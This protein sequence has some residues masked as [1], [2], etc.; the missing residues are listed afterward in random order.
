MFEST[1]SGPGRAL[2]VLSPLARAP[3][4]WEGA[5]PQQIE[6]LAAEL[7]FPSARKKNSCFHRPKTGKGKREKPEGDET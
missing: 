5:L 3:E 7:L 4:G 1:T 6:A 2:L